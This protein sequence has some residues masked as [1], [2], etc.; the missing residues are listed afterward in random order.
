[1]FDR[2]KRIAY[3][4]FDAQYANGKWTAGSGAVFPTSTN[5]R[6]PDGWTSADAAGMSITAGLIRYDEVYGP[7]PIR[8]ALRCTVRQ[9]NGYVFPASHKSATDSGGMPLG[10]RFRLKP[11]FDYRDIPRRCRRSSRP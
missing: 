3:E 6:R 9:I 2:S 4:L 1:M 10:M 11:S 5:Y 8:H 7:N